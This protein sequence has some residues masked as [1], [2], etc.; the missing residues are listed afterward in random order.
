MVKTWNVVKLM[1][2]VH[3]PLYCSSSQMPTVNFHNSS[4]GLQTT[5]HCQAPAKQWE[6]LLIFL[7]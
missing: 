5:C 1:T 2:I 7:K 3:A 4:A 6:K